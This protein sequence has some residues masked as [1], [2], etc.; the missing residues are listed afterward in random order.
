MKKAIFVFT[1]L[2]SLVLMF[3][4][5][6]K[7]EINSKPETSITGPGE[8]MSA[9]RMYPYD[10]IKQDVYL[11]E[12]KKANQ[13]HTDRNGE[14][15][16]EFVGPTNIGGRITDIEMPLGQSQIMYIGAASG[17]ILKTENAGMSWQQKFLNYLR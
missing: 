12:M 13:M 4:L 11:R 5:F 6:P 10:E 1:I 2:L 15:I 14:I 16:W 7:D 3:N 17:G 9:Q 8:W